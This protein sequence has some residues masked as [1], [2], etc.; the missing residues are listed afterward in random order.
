[1]EL[2]FSWSLFR[3]PNSPSIFSR[4]F[5][6]LLVNRFSLFLINKTRSSLLAGIG[7]P[8][9]ISQSQYY[10][11]TLCEFFTVIV[12]GCLHWNQSD[13]KST[14]SKIFLVIP[15]NL[16]NAGTLM[17]SIL[18]W[19]SCSHRVFSRFFSIVLRAP[20]LIGIAVTFCWVSPIFFHS[21]N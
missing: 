4:F 8:I 10:Y 9:C 3:I 18:P 6:N 7:T 5:R 11:F 13:S 19:V 14:V 1:M 21:M 12:T 2:W 16:N 17:I 15:A 20:T